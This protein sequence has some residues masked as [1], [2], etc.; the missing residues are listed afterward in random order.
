MMSDCSCSMVSLMMGVMPVDT[1]QKLEMR[2][3]S[4][5]SHEEGT[6]YAAEPQT[7]LEISGEVG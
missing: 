1:L 7:G 4:M 2:V 6:M 5:R 3:R